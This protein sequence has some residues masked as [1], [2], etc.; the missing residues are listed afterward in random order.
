MSD[1]LILYSKNKALIADVKKFISESLYILT[2]TDNVD[3]LRSH[4]GESE[5]SLLL[6]DFLD[7]SKENQNDL[8]DLL[9]DFP[10]QLVILIVD[11][12]NSDEFLTMVENYHVYD[13]IGYPIYKIKLLFTLSKAMTYG[14]VMSKISD[15]KSN[16]KQV[17]ESM[18]KVFDWRKE[19]DTRK[20][21]S[22]ANEL[23]H[24]I[25]ISFFHGSGLG[26]LISTLSIMFAKA[27]LDEEKK[28]YLVH[29]KVY[30]LLK[31]NYE[32]ILKLSDSL[33]KTQSI[34]SEKNYYTKEVVLKDFYTTLVS[35]VKDMKNVAAIKKQKIVMGDFPRDLVTHKIIA[36]LPNVKLV[37]EEL[38]TNAIKYSEDGDTIYILFS[39]DKSDI[40]I[41]I[42]NPAYKNSDGTIGI[43][44]SNAHKIFEPF[45]RLTNVVDDRF[46]Q[47]T[48]RFGLGLT[49]VNKI[50]DLHRGNIAFYTTDNN[51]R[52]EGNMKDVCV[53]IR[54][55]II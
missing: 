37:F 5:T 29:E 21:E 31:D 39:H 7:S 26:S 17:F 4:L 45:F 14:R 46:M 24:Q 41:R 2:V 6:Y 18:I 12:E 19:L 3:K 52:K 42:L 27:K 48:F 23:I 11:R 35:I 44:E 30:H 33:T 49:V 28:M 22:L 50:I 53:W 20:V 15:F 36:D 8:A 25:N 32:E 54:F 16:E 43:T 1:K 51:M 34:L 55:P 40:G 47:E 38:I 9:S 13:L 10:F